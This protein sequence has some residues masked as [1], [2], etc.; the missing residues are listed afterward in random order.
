MPSV[1]DE[2]Q[3]QEER[4]CKWNDGAIVEITGVCMCLC[5]LVV[6]FSDISAYKLLP[7]FHYTSL[8]THTYTRCSSNSIFCSVFLFEPKTSFSFQH[9]QQK[10]QITS[11]NNICIK[12]EKNTNKIIGMNE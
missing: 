5:A 11:N 12:N 2:E 8:H 1:Q 10:E 3:K 6:C 7:S 9:T 4:R